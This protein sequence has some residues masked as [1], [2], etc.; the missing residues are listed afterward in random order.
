MG[1]SDRTLLLCEQRG[2][3]GRSG[4]AGLERRPAI[5]CERAVGERRQLDDVPIVELLATGA[6][7]RHTIPKGIAQRVLTPPRTPLRPKYSRVHG[8]E[9]PREY[10][11]GSW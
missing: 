8:C 1:Q 7:H 5:V 3:L 6:V 9:L 2:E 11:P 10:A 4:D